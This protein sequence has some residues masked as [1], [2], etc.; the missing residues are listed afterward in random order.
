MSRKT[1]ELEDKLQ[2]A[3][4]DSTE[5]VDILH[6]LARQLG[7]ED[8]E[9]AKEF[10]KKAYELALKLQ[11]PKGLVYDRRNKGIFYFFQSE[12]EKATA[13]FLEALAWCQENGDK[14]GQADA[15]TFL[16][17]IYW[18]FGDQDSTGVDRK[19]SRHIH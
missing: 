13:Y 1:R 6:E 19:V 9:K 17:L 15:K 10:A 4:V 11:Y 18:S 16:G 3:K 8:L 2:K 12:I 7:R 5:R 14:R